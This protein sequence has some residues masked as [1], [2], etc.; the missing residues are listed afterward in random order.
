MDSIEKGVRAFRKL[1]KRIGLLAG[2]WPPGKRWDGSYMQKAQEKRA[3]GMPFTITDHLRGMVYAMLSAG[4]RWDAYLRCVDPLTGRLPDIDAVFAQYDPAAIAEL[5]AVDTEQRLAACHCHPRFIIRQMAYL[6]NNA[7]KLQAWQAAYG[8]VDR[9]Y[10]ILND[11]Q[12]RAERLLKAIIS[13]GETKLQG[14]GLALGAEY[15]RNVGYPMAKPDRHIRELFGS[16]CLGLS[17]EALAKP[18]YAMG[19]VDAIAS[20]TGNNP[21]YVDYIFWASVAKGYGGMSPEE[22]KQYVEGD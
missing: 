4:V 9:F 16:G 13:P 1:E 18:V 15:L 7:V 12:T 8:T 19:L 20:K 22:I 17:A 6:K 3:A 11:G 14:L 5:R 21:A 2:N 10:H